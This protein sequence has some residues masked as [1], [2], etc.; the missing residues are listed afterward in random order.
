MQET[1]ITQGL[2]LMLY[3][4]GTVFVF[5]SL[6]VVMTSLMSRIVLRI[7]PP[8][9]QDTPEVLSNPV[10]VEPQILKVIEKAISLHRNKR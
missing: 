2:D 7:A 10:G 3:G 6:L 9:V 4:M 8:E 5:L 1:L